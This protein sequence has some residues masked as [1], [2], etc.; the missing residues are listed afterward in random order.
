ML[1]NLRK[2]CWRL[3]HWKMSP[4]SQLSVP[5]L[6]E[7]FTKTQALGWRV[8]ISIGNQAMSAK[9]NLADKEAVYQALEGR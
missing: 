4:N 7:K 1:L 8:R 6:G 5:R 9:V 3:L 2:G